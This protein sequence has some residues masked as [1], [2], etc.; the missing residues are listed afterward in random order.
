MKKL[1]VLSL[2][3]VLAACGGATVQEPGSSSSS[4][5]VALS[6]PNCSDA[7]HDNAPMRLLTAKQ[8][9][10]LLTDTFS[11]LNLDAESIVAMLPEDQA[12]AGFS[13]NAG[14][15][16]GVKNLKNYLEVA[17]TIAALASDDFGKLIN[18]NSSD[19]TCIRDYA[20]KYGSALFRKSLDNAEA[21]E[22]VSL[23]QEAGMGPDAIERVTAALVLDGR[24]LYQYEE[25]V[26][27]RE[28]LS[29]LEIANKLALL[30][31]NRAP[32]AELISLAESGVLD[33]KAGVRAQA[34]KMLDDDRAVEGLDEFYKGWMAFIEPSELEFLRNPLVGVGLSIESA[35][36]ETQRF[37]SHITLVED[38]DFIGLMTSRKA[39]LTEDIAEN[40]DINPG[41]LSG[42]RY[43]GG[44]EV[45]LGA[46]RSGIMTRLAYL[47]H[48]AEENGPQPTIRGAF[49]RN[50]IMCQSFP[51]PGA[52]VQD[53]FPLLPNDPNMSKVE[54]LKKFHL[55]VPGCAGCHTLLDPVGFGFEKYDQFGAYRENYILGNGTQ[56]AIDD[57]GEIVEV[58][59]DPSDII[60]E[61]EGAIALSDL[62][63]TSTKAQSCYAEFWFRYAFGRYPTE[64]D[65]CAVDK[66]AYEFQARDLSLKELILAV[67]ESNAFRFRNPE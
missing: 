51:V 27:Q 11:P 41:T 34:L 37:A 6:A 17:E 62:V 18:C 20:K 31:W 63:A 56:Q 61:F 12:T 66:L 40:Y 23:A 46:Q 43:R 35:Y 59:T 60:G 14:A 22:F 54:E 36:A 67:T 65:Q 29:G 52:D 5:G 32:D 25:D 28:Q 55:E 10:N 30:I 8:L 38:G 47:V 45:T 33:T 39:F 50:Q 44:T 64:A 9:S 42:D 19:D 2:F 1:L 26:D 15:L 58:N 53:L 49:F 48:G 21:N 16:M 13:N 3:T 7:G 57:T 24:T 4:S